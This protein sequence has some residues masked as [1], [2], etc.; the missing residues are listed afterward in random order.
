MHHQDAVGVV[1]C[2]SCLR[3]RELGSDDIVA[4]GDGRHSCL[5]CLE[6]MV[7]NTADA[8]PLYQVRIMAPAPDAAALRR[9]A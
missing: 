1:S 3:L 5:M 9:G 4:I 2:T 7:H 6:L 8:Q